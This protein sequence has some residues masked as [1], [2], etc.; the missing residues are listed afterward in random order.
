MSFCY[1]EINKEIVP[2]NISVYTDT[3]IGLDNYSGASF[4]PVRRLMVSSV[5]C[6]LIM[7]VNATEKSIA[8]SYFSKQELYCRMNMH[9]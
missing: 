3:K 4:S 8:A 6:L 5:F 1:A 2:A 9:G 7:S